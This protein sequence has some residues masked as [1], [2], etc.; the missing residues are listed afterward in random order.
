MHGHDCIQERP[1][2]GKLDLLHCTHEMRIAV[3]HSCVA[4]VL[5]HKYEGYVLAGVMKWCDV[6]V[7]RS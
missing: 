4:C 7:L 5:A 3:P 2:R 6:A 1:S